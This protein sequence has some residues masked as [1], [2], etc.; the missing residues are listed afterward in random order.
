[1]HARTRFAPSPTG[2][3]HLGGV[4]TALYA[5]LYAKQNK[6]DFILRIED[7]DLE[8]STQESVQLILDSLAWLGLGYDEGP[9]YQTQRLDRYREIAAKLLEENKAYRCYCSKERLETLREQ[10]IAQKEKPR[11]DGHCRELNLSD[12]ETPHVIRFRNP[13]EGIVEVHDQI[14]GLVKFNNTE[15]DDLVIIR[16]DGMPTYNFSVVIDDSD[17]QIT[18]VIRGDD[19]LNNTP[20]QINILTSLNAPIPIYAH[21]PMI[22]NE[23]GKRFSKRH[24]AMSVLQYRDDGYLPQAVLNYLVRLGWSH[25]NQ[26][27][28][29]VDEMIQYF[30]LK[31]IQK[32]PAAFNPEKLLW[33]NQHYLKHLPIETIM[34]HL[35]WQAKHRD[36][37]TDKGPK[38]IEVAEAQKER[39]K[40]LAELVEKSQFFYEDHESPISIDPKHA[41][42][43]L[44]PALLDLKNQLS[45]LTDWRDE[46]IHEILLQVANAHQLKLGQLAQPVRTVITGG[47]ISPPIDKTIRL[48]GKEGVVKRLEQTVTKLLEQRNYSAAPPVVSHP[49]S[50][51][52]VKP[53][54]I[55]DK[56]GSTT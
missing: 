21:L 33:L 35:L 5:W 50:E 19:H 16:S 49:S 31:K 41:V 27:I 3:L 26:E 1:M 18:H 51:S 4:R 17:M 13:K 47:T 37:N 43:E 25:G 15:L 20:R 46:C 36:L 54:E 23:E 55:G 45:A 56:H 6:G 44:A 24:G 22:L 40:T 29:S 7:T 10:Q 11:Y 53:D 42:P 34:P 38:L 14:R 9:F 30:D 8:R 39:V 48:L 2:Y 52:L 28:F 32:A 12:N